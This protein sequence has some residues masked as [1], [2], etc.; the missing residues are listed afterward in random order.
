MATRSI[1]GYKRDN[2]VKK[3]IDTEVRGGGYSTVEDT[4]PY[5]DRTGYPVNIDAEE[6][7]LWNFRK[8]RGIG[9]WR[10]DR[11]KTNKMN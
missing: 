9:L 6:Y 8:W 3:W 10:A 5:N 4:T 1:V 11:T 7:G 2:G